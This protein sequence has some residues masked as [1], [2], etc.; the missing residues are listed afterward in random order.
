MMGRMYQVIR[1]SRS[2]FVPIRHLNYHVR[3]WGEPRPGQ[4]PLVMVHG[5]MDVAA[6]YQFVVDAFDADH[7]V[8]IGR[9]HV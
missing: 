7:H 2:E 9:A 6:S 4:A 8:K 5:W 1:A 3:L